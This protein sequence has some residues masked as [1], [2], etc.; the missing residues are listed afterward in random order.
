MAKAKKTAHTTRRQTPA[1]QIAILKALLQSEKFDKDEMLK[2]RNLALHKI[3]ELTKLTN[4]AHEA[5]NLIFS[6]MEIFPLSGIDPNTH[7]AS[8]MGRAENFVSRLKN[9]ITR[10]IELAEAEISDLKSQIKV[11][12]ETIS[13]IVHHEI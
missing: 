5:L 7:S 13:L 6:E 4:Q 2:E 1:Q 3:Q 11:L 9:K 12:Q 10:E 8:I